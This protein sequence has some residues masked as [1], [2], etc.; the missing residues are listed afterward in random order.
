MALLFQS[1]WPWQFMEHMQVCVN[2]GIYVINLPHH[3]TRAGLSAP[4]YRWENWST[5]EVSNLPTEQEKKRIQS[6]PSQACLM[7]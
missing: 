3:S 7:R 5:E 4:S 2:H 6:E 1:L